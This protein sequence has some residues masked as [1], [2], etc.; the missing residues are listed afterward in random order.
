DEWLNGTECSSVIAIPLKQ[1]DQLVGMWC[2]ERNS[3]DPPFRSNEYH[4]TSFLLS[5]LGPVLGNALAHELERKAVAEK[6]DGRFE[7]MIGTSPKMHDLFRQIT[8]VAP[9]DISVLIVG[10]SVTGK[11]LVARSLHQ[12]S[13][14]LTGPFVALNCSAIPETLIESELFGFSRGAFTGASAPKPG[15][16]ERAHGGTLFLDEIG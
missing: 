8:H 5:A 9:I 16:I 13:R 4:Q 7:A 12:M 15:V 1:K 6:T 2:F 14:R 10:E 3:T 11:E